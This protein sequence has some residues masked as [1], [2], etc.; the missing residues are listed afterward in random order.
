[1]QAVGYTKCDGDLTATPPEVVPT[2]LAEAAPAPVGGELADGIYDLVGE[3]Q[4]RVG[5]SAEY[6]RAALRL[7]DAGTHAEFIYDPGSN[8]E[9]D[10][11]HRLLDVSRY[12]STTLN[13]DV[14]CPDTSVIFRHYQR[15]YSASGDDLWLFQDS[16]LE[17]YEKRH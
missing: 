11:P 3:Y 12:D 6:E 2:G 9:A 17:V 5:I 14:T 1:M 10:S 15:G 4:Y 8:A 16:L 7:F 13:F